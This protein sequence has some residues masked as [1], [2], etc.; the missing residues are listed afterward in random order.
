[1]ALLMG[2]VT[3]MGGAMDM[4]FM[5]AMDMLLDMLLMGAIDMG[6]DML[7]IEAM[8]M[9][10]MGAM[11]IPFIMFGGIDMPLFKASAICCCCC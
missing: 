3:D 5:G 10:F 2:G 4:L 7:F 11:D 1:M 8:A 6:I 9:P